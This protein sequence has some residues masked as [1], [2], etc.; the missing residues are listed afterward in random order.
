MGWTIF[1]F[2]LQVFMMELN[3]NLSVNLHLTFAF[4]D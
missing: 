1:L 2:L 3:K 4:Y